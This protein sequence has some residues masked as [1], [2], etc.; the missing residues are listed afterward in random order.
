MYKKVGIC[1]LSFMVLFF[2]GMFDVK[3]KGEATTSKT[4][5]LISDKK[6]S[7]IFDLPNVT[8]IN[9]VSVDDGYV[10][11]K[12]LSGDTL[13]VVVDGSKIDDEEWDYKYFDKMITNYG[14][15]NKNSPNTYQY[16]DSTP[17]P[18]DTG[19]SGVLKKYI[20]SG[21]PRD[22]KWV[23]NQKNKWYDDGIYS[24]NLSS[25]SV[26]TSDSDTK[27]VTN[28]TSSWYNYGGYSGWLSSYVSGSGPDYSKKVTK[29]IVSN[30]NCKDASN[31][32][33]Y[34]D[35]G[36]SG[37]LSYI[38]CDT[39]LQ[40]FGVTL[41]KYYGNVTNKGETYYRYRGNVTK[42]AQYVTRYKGTV[43]RPDSR[44]W[45]YKGTVYKGKWINQRYS[46]SVKVD[47]EDNQKPV[48]SFSTDNDRYSEVSGYNV[49]NLSGNSKDPDGDSVIIHYSVGKRIGKINVLNNTQFNINIPIDSQITEGKHQIR[50]WADDGDY[51]GKSETVTKNII[52]DKSDPSASLLE[53]NQE[54][55]ISLDFTNV[56]GDIAGLHSSPY[57]VERS[58]NGGN[59]NTRFNWNSSDSFTDM[60]VYSNTKYSYRGD[61]RDSVGH[62][63]NK[64]NLVEFVTSPKI[65]NREND[66]L[67]D[68]PNTIVMELEKSLPSGISLEIKRSGTLIAILDSGKT[69]TDSGLDFERDYTYEIIAV[70]NDKNGNRLESV[71]IKKTVTTGVSI[72]KMTLFHEFDNINNYYL[73]NRTVF[74]DKVTVRGNLFFNQG[75]KVDIIYSDKN[76]EGVEEFN[77]NPYQTETFNLEGKYKD[78]EV[79]EVVARMSEKGINMEEEASVRVDIKPVII[80]ELDV[81][82]NLF[83][84]IY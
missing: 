3:A 53:N 75:G 76:G 18:N 48:V 57:R 15:P 14:T 50:L 63:S 10:V 77:L 5:S 58:V 39:S 71:P 82:G 36:Y 32:L 54:Y 78:K 47:Y 37:Y 20:K 4:T 30:D 83:N 33:W 17:D 24:G 45:K 35:N 28:Q 70:S 19:Y 51:L 81:S 46:Y 61:V 80:N 41:A 34:S 23:S 8:K 25:Y 27:W 2:T 65:K 44:V 38:G 1:V 67:E 74:S 55:Q 69:F 42:P 12:I 56:D 64:T 59:F 31:S 52:V 49:I 13:T 16:G 29:S 40:M 62:I 43:V 84:T 11:S 68:E 60:N 22:T 66:Y 79:Y 9:S 72:L 7:I 26:K 21:I 73:V 6:Q